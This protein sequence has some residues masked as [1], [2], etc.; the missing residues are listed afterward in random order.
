MKVPVCAL[1]IVSTGVVSVVCKTANAIP[2]IVILPIRAAPV[3]FAA[4]EYCTVPEPAPGT[5]DVTVSHDESLDAFQP[6]PET[7]VC[8]LKLPAP[9]AWGHAA[10]GGVMV[11]GAEI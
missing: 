11:T 8:R 7:A 5:A 9:P 6:N 10:L 1:A 3:A 4:T 2:A